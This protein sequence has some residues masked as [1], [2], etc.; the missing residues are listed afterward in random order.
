MYQYGQLSFWCN[1]SRV[2]DLGRYDILSS[3]N[4]DYKKKKISSQLL[5]GQNQFSF[6]GT[7]LNKF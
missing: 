3:T 4:A 5:L 6:L 7:D 1:L 2:F